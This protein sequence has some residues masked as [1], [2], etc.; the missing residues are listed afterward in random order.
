MN[1]RQR[2]AAWK[3]TDLERLRSKIRELEDE[4]SKLRN[5]L[6]TDDLT[7]LGSARRLRAELEGA[8]QTQLQEGL[9]PTLLFLDVDHFKAINETHGHLA[10]GDILRQVGRLISVTIRLTDLGF[11][12]GGDEFVV[13]V[14]GGRQQAILVAERLRQKIENHRFLIHGLQGQARV[15]ITVSVGVRE[16]HPGKTVEMVLEEADRAMFEAKRR[17]RNTIVAA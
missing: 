7:G 1:L 17:H 9:R 10:A 13:L 12:Y 5:E 6:S 2:A 4:N 8:M 16:M 15:A 14:S 3:N 11:R